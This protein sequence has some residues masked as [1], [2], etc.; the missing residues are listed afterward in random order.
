[1]EGAADM[2]ERRTGTD[3]EA[4]MLRAVDVLR[5]ASGVMSRAV[6]DGRQCTPGE[7]AALAAILEGCA[8]RLF[9]CASESREG[10]R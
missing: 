7:L 9:E 5:L 1:M 10:E 6:S 2:E 8:D 3:Y 4:T